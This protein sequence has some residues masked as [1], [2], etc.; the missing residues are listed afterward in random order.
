MAAAAERVAPTFHAGCVR[1]RQSVIK[2]GLVDRPHALLWLTKTYIIPASM[3]GSQ[4]RGT[5]Y[6]KEGAKMDC[7]LQTGHLFYSACFG[8]KR[9][10]CNLSVLRVC[11]QEPLQVYCKLARK[12]LKA[13]R[14][15]NA[16]PGVKCWTAEILESFNSS[17]KHEQ[18]T[19]AVLTGAAIDIKDF[20]T[21][22]H[23]RLC[24]EWRN[25]ENVQP[26]GHCHKQASY[27]GL[28][29]NLGSCKLPH[30][31]EFPLVLQVL[32]VLR[33]ATRTSFNF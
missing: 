9:S 19:Q 10:T 24:R 25:L 26:R 2:H 15:L 4:I 32:A 22:L 8:V 13:D 23:S 20:A 18:Y 21:N 3:Y 27:R 31:Q 7:P 11:G 1:D 5:S 14:T 29:Y 30:R 33:L 16:A 28:S 17:E 12:V 6:M